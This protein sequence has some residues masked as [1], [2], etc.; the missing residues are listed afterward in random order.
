MAKRN[1]F[2]LFAPL[3]P[4]IGISFCGSTRNSREY[5]RSCAPCHNQQRDGC[6]MSSASGIR[7]RGEWLP[8]ARVMLQ[9]LRLERTDD[10]QAD[11]A[12]SRP[13]R[14]CQEEQLRRG[15]ARN[16]S[17]LIRKP[18]GRNDRTAKRYSPARKNPHATPR[19]R[20]SLGAA[21]AIGYLRDY[22]ERIAEPVEAG[23]FPVHRSPQ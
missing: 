1:N 5:S 20:L 15:R 4:I 2:V 23:E 7:T 12:A 16:P 17:A 14:C 9:R 13:R 6:A 10:V 22:R 21:G 3:W 19:Q 11:A 8:L 18:P